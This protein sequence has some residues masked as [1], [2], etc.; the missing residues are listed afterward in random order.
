MENKT[1]L[2]TVDG[3]SISPKTEQKAGVQG[4]HNITDVRFEGDILIEAVSN[5]DVVKA[6]I[7]FI[8]GA[9]GFYSTGFLDV[10]SDEEDGTIYVTCPIPDNVTNAGGVAHVHLVLTKIAYEDEKAVENQVYI[11]PPGKLLYTHSGVGS[12]SEYAYRMGISSALVNAEIFAGRAEEASEA[13]EETKLKVETAEADAYESAEQAN[14]NATDADKSAKS[15][16]ESAEAAK[17]AQ[18][19]AESSADEAKTIV[20]DADDVLNEIKTKL[21]NGEFKGEKGDT[22][23]SGVYLGSGE[24]PEGYN[25]QIDPDGK[26]IEVYNKEEADNK[27]ATKEEVGNIETALDNIIAEQEAIIAIQNALIGGDSV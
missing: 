25:V 20:G 8:D 2:F 24:M 9:G 3:D 27:F 14:K 26:S 23:V 21:A 11:S 18:E 6:R 5:P 19:A 22:G 10:T 16:A 17:S 15:A 12:P 13:A 4:Q 1:I 7:Q